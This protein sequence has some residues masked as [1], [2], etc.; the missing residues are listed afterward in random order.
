MCNGYARLRAILRRRKL[1][2]DRRNDEGLST[3]T[4]PDQ[5]ATV[6]RRMS[7]GGLEALGTKEA[8]EREACRFRLFQVPTRS[9][10]E[11]PA[12]AALSDDAMTLLTPDRIS[13]RRADSSR[14]S[15]HSI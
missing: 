8:E 12:P 11:R 9:A 2:V 3:G 7:V 10:N 4:F 1:S 6:I 14:T 5:P 13:F 15:G